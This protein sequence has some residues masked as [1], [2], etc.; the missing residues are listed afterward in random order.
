MKNEKIITILLIRHYDF[1]SNFIY[2][3]SGKGYTHASIALDNSQKCFYS[4]NF[5]G[6][7][8]EYPKKKITLQTQRKSVCYQL[9][10]SEAVYGEIKK[11][12]SDFLE[13]QNEYQYS[14][15]GLFLCLLQ[16]P[17]RFQKNY[18]CSRFVA[19]ILTQSGAVGLK[20]DS[21]LYLPNQFVEEL[22]CHP[23]LFNVL[24]NAV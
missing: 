19:E 21:S 24:Y 6:F 5:K 18:F 20:R 2:M 10:V 1:F 14:R 16:I 7:S 22:E 13:K 15:L 23:Q 3:I 4:F 9:A 17:H 11:R 12:I 8:V